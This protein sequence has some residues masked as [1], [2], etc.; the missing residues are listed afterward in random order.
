MSI[1]VTDDKWMHEPQGLLDPDD[2]LVLKEASVDAPAVVMNVREALEYAEKEEPEKFTELKKEQEKMA[3]RLLTR[4]ELPVF[5]QAGEVTYARFKDMM[6]HMNLAQAH[7]VRRMRVEE[8]RTW[9]SVA[10]AC[11]LMITSGEW[12]W[13]RQIWIPP[14]NQLAGM[15]LCHHAAR[16][17]GGDFMEPPW[18]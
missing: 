18:N 3:G 16:L 10:R 2:E 5:L 11:H 4:E 12:T 17:L 6:W 14:S 9:R 7:E 1:L 13:G 8:R 15:A